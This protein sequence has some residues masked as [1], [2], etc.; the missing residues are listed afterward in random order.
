MQN[1]SENVPS[2][3]IELDCAKGIGAVLV[4]L[5]HMTTYPRIIRNIIYSFHMPLFFVIS[6]ILIANKEKTADFITYLKNKIKS[7]LIPALFFE[8]IM[9]AW[10]VVKNIIEHSLDTV[11]LGKR[12]IG[13][14]LQI[15]YSDYSGSLW[16]F[17]TFFLA[18]IFLYPIWKKKKRFRL[19][20]AIFL[21][22]LSY[23]YIHI[24]PDVFLPW[25][26]EIIPVCMAYILIGGIMGSY[27][28]K[29]NKSNTFFLIVGMI[30]WVIS[31]GINEMV[32]RHSYALDC[33][34][35][36]NVVIDTMM[37]CSGSVVVI[38]IS[39]KL[40]NSVH[41]SRLK[42]GMAFIGKNSLAYYGIQAIMVGI[43][44]TIIR[45]FVAEEILYK[46]GGGYN[47]YYVISDINN[48]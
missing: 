16:F 4:I 6:G 48:S 36:D 8:F 24:Y 41:L 5:G 23:E 33:H 19:Y 3:M 20:I 18:N 7:I 13:I 32:L 9:Y 42:E 17:A 10:L 12:F 40:V 46:L 30:I 11:S 21:L 45:K 15:G 38:I 27:Y 25:H 37:V 26:F 31:W 1:T 35:F 2:R 28:E 44:N 39:K 34:S 14:F 22:I 47:F 29:S 43:L